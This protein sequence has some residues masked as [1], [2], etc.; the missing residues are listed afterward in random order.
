MARAM[1]CRT[2]MW[3]ALVSLPPRARRTQPTLSLRFRCAAP[4][5][6]PR[7][8]A[9][10]RGEDVGLRAELTK[11]DRT[12]EARAALTRPTDP[13]QEPCRVVA[14]NGAQIGRAETPIC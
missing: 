11:S 13:R 12:D 8:G 2:F 9:P 14:L 5:S 6:W 1:R 7:T 3:P 10:S 4:S